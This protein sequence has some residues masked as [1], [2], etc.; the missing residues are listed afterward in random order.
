[1]DR[2]LDEGRGRPRARDVERPAERAVGPD[3]VEAVVEL[4]ITVVPP[5]V[6]VLGPREPSGPQVGPDIVRIALLYRADRE[7]AVADRV[8]RPVGVAT[9]EGV[10]GQPQERSVSAF[11]IRQRLR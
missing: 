10:R 3:R 2:L 5:E 1:A 4:D 9:V 8:V 6:L 11:G 7:V